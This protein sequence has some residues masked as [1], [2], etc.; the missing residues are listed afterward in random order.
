MVKAVY[1]N[2]YKEYQKFATFHTF[3]GRLKH[4]LT[5]SSIFLALAVVFFILAMFGM[6]TFASGSVIC[7]IFVFI[8]P[9]LNWIMLKIRVR[10][11][12]KMNPNFNVTKNTYTFNESDFNL[13]IDVNKRDEDHKMKYTE[14]YRVY[15]TRTNYYL[16][17]DYVRALIV[18]KSGIKD[19]T[20]EEL[21]IIF[22]KNL[23]KKFYSK[24]K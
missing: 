6:T 7:L 10:K 4:I 5:F 19:G 21:S 1:N 14:L 16:Y 3:V 18:T 8:L 15:E 22:E 20:A 13:H 17:L 11:A 12:V 24:K 9:V 2:D 23:G